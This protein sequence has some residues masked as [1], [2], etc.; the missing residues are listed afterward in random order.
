MIVYIRKLLNPPPFVDAS[1]LAS[2]HRLSEP[3]VGAFQ[4]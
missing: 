2:S 3:A 4:P 1:F